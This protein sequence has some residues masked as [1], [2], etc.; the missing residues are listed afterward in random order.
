MASKLS[1]FYYATNYYNKYYSKILKWVFMSNE[2]TNFTY[3]LTEENKLLLCQF[4]AH[5]TKS[6]LE[7]VIQYRI[8][9]ENDLELKNH[10]I[11]ITKSSPYSSC[12]DLTCFYGRRIGWYILVRILKPKV[13]IETGVEKG[14]G[15]VVIASALKRNFEDG[16]IGRYYGTDI[17]PEAG[18]LF[19]GVYKNFGELLI[20]DS[21]QSLN[22]FHQKI[23]LFINDSD[24]SLAYER[25]EY[26]TIKNKL[27]VNSFIISDNAHCSPELSHFSQKENRDYLFFKEDPLN[28]WYPGAGI[29]ISWKS[30]I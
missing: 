5:I 25:N 11:K 12:A 21:I 13:V 27:D 4:I 3:D 1:R 26:N 18:Y 16:H 28:H 20:G 15:S 23:D 7:F 10:I 8:E 2:Y 24:H 22:N 17:N 9:L 14:L 29:G 6:N 30:Y 19:E